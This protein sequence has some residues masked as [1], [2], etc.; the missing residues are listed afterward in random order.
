MDI[1]DQTSDAVAGMGQDMESIKEIVKVVLDPE[2]IEQLTRL[3]PENINGMVQGQ[4]N[5]EFLETHF[6]FRNRIIDKAIELKIKHNVA[7]KGWRQE[8]LNEFFKS[9]QSPMQ[10]NMMR[11]L[12]WRQ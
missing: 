1:E 11:R 10:Q 7:D 12:L 3:L 4:I 6:K 9:I 8:K 2:N 5:N